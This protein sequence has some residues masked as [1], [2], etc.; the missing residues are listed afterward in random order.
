MM[1]R[2]KKGKTDRALWLEHHQLKN[3]TMNS[4]DMSEHRGFCAAMKLQLLRVFSS[5]YLPATER[6]NMQTLLTPCLSLF[7]PR[8]PRDISPIDDY[9]HLCS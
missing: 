5:I 4:H 8:N 2:L 6:R 3:T 9:K 1:D 7:H